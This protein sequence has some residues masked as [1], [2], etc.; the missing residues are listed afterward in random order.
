MF[1]TMY[2][3]RRSYSNLYRIEPS[4]AQ[5]SSLALECWYIALGGAIVLG[6]VMQF[7]LAAAFWVGRIDVPFLHP[8]VQLFGYSF[9]YVPTHFTKD[10]LVH[11]AH[12]HPYIE[13]LAQMYLMRLRHEKFVSEAGAAWRQLAILSLFPWLSKHRVFDAEK[14]DQAKKSLVDDQLGRAREPQRPVYMQVA[15]AI[16]A[17]GKGVAE[18]AISPVSKL[19][20]RELVNWGVSKSDDS[21]DGL[22][23]DEFSDAAG[24]IWK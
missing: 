10:L 19:D 12:R 4:V 13:R 6:R 21:S 15:S 20:V 18:K 7:L 3:R 16:A 23:A 24:T 5:V 2:C 8:D 1:L 22:K 17:E 9:D 14:V 11:E